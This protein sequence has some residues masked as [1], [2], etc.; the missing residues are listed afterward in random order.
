MSFSTWVAGAQAQESARAEPDQV[1]IDRDDVVAVRAKDEAR[2]DGPLHRAGLAGGMTVERAAQ[3]AARALTL[4]GQSRGGARRSANFAHHAS[5]IARGP[6]F[7]GRLLDGGEIPAVARGRRLR[8]QALIENR[9][10]ARR[11]ERDHQQ[12]LIPS[13]R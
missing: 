12:A 4:F 1:S 5:S 8:I 13:A 9:H 7:A 3:G 10:G 6:A 11:S 2:V